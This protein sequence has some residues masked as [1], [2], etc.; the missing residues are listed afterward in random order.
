MAATVIP[1]LMAVLVNPLMALNLSPLD[2]AV[3]EYYLSFNLIYTPIIGFFIID[4]YQRKYYVL[5]AEERYKLKG[6]IIKMLLLFSEF[7]SLFCIIALFSFV[8]ITNVS[9]AFFP[10]GVLA[11]LTSYA[12]MIFTLQ[13][14]EF[15]MEGNAR[16]FFLY[17][18]FWGVV[19]VCLS[20]LLVV[21]LKYGAIGKM[22]AGF[23]CALFPLIFVLSK[24]GVYLKEPFNVEIFKDVLKFGYPLVLAAILSYFTAGYDKLLLE[25]EGLI[26]ELGYYSVAFSMASYLNVFST[27]VKTTFQP[28]MFKAIARKSL[29]TV[30]KV[31]LV[32]IASVFIIVVCFIIC[33]PVIIDILTAGRYVR[34]TGMC[35]IISLSVLSSTIYYQISQYTYGVGQ[36]KLTL[37]SKIVGTVINIA[38]ITYLISYYGCYGAAWSTVV[39]YVTYAIC[40][41]FFLYINRKVFLCNGS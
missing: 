37:K 21:I 19:G 8:K 18:V 38:I 31:A 20:L 14:A 26:E 27:A 1:S 17:S 16:S 34:S 15:K 12:N 5:S 7:M 33:C 23:L 11:I 6:T 10:Y 4:Y 24:S 9:F 29:R 22:S 41:L 40:N 25:R 2:Y 39:G 35:Q 30:I 36:S 28:D 13:L 3:S 32:V